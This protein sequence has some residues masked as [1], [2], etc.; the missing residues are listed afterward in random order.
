MGGGFGWIRLSIVLLLPQIISQIRNSFQDQVGPYYGEIRHLISP[1]VCVLLENLTNILSAHL[2]DRTFIQLADTR[3]QSS[4]LR[5]SRDNLD[6]VMA[7][8]FFFVSCCFCL[9]LLLPETQRCGVHYPDRGSRRGWTGP[10][11]FRW[12]REDAGKQDEVC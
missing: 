8:F 12:N 9:W 2:L 10:G 4:V 5:F 7:V 11:V 6:L 3:R 1:F